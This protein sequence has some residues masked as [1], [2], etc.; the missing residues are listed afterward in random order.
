MNS[1]N[2]NKSTSNLYFQTDTIRV[3]NDDILKIDSIDEKSIDLIITSPPYDDKMSYDDYLL[4]TREWVLK[5]YKL[6]KDDGRFCL[7]IPLDKN[8]GGQQSVCADITTIAKQMGWK[9]HSTIIWNEQNIS[10]R[11][12]WGPGSAP[13]LLVLLHRLRLLLFFIKTSGRKP[14]EA[15]NQI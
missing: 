7:N 9:Y 4:F 2:K 12:A 1:I 8:E 13:Q 10:M 15:R 5:C 11:T 14:V 3:Y 6:S